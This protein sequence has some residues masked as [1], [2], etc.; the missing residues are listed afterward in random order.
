L[1]RYISQFEK[2]GIGLLKKYKYLLISLV[3]FIICLNTWLITGSLAEKTGKMDTVTSYAIFSF[4]G[5]VLFLFTT[6]VLSLI[7]IV[8][9]IKN[10]SIIN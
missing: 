8:T 5:T 4:L 10:K 6:L 9:K 7:A 2:E 3:L 1:I